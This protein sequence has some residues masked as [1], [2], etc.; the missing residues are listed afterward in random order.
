MIVARQTIVDFWIDKSD[1]VSIECI[2]V[3]NGHG[4]GK[5]HDKSHVIQIY[6]TEI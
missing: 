1:R 4:R 6:K 2:T 3:A 5:M